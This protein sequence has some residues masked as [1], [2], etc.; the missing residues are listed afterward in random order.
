VTVVF[1]L[2]IV[3]LSGVLVLDV[4]VTVAR[5]RLRRESSESAAAAHRQ[6]MSEIRRHPDA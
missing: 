6:L 3:L 1:V 5:G 4:A 2:V